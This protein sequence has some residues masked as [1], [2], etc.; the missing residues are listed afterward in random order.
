MDIQVSISL[1]PSERRELAQILGCTQQELPAK[2]APS[3][4][5][6]GKEYVTM[7]LGQKVFSRGS[8]ILE[9]RLFLLIQDAFDNQIPDEQDVS[10][11]F[12]TTTNESRSLIRSVMSKY[13]YQLG[14][15]IGRSLIRVLEAAEHPEPDGHFVLTINSVNLIDE[16]NRVLADIDGSLSPVSKK[17]GSV[18]TYEVEPSSY[19]RL[20]DRL[21]AEA[22]A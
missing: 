22:V 3:L 11:L 13:Q 10:R 17:R 21:H 8:D 4:N 12:Q 6:A 20:C 9:H 15:A 16:L 18:S 7:F 1:T 14:D 2:L 19:S 5:A